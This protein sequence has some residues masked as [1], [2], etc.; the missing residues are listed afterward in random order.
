[1]LAASHDAQ[2]STIGFYLSNTGG[3]SAQAGAAIT[4]SGNTGQQLTGLTAADLVGI[5]VLWILNGNNGAPNAQV[6]GNQASIAA[7]IT[8][9]GVLSMHDRNVNQGGV[10]ASTYLPGGAGIAFTSL[11]GANIDV[12]T[13]GTAVTNGPSGTINN[14]DLDGGNFSNHGFASLGSLPAGAVAIL[15]NGT[16]GNIVDFYYGFGA[17]AVYYSSIPLDFYLSGGGNNPPGNAIRTIYAP[18]ELGFEASLANAAVPEPASLLLLGSGLAG[19]ASRI[20]SR[21]RRA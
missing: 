20:R 21:R 16:A 7:F 4:A 10:S 19:V 12:E 13:G 14:T 5:D 6:T 11:L 9:G 15:N 17:G 1:M 8:A 2:A 3:I 18:N